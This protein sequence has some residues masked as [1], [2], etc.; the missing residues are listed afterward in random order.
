MESM[1]SHTYPTR[2][3]LYFHLWNFNPEQHEHFQI[4]STEKF[5]GY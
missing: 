5:K 2:L 1:V 3:Q 4:A